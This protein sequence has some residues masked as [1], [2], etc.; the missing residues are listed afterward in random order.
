MA[1]LRQILQDYK[2]CV[3]AYS[4]GVDSV[5]L[6]HVAHQVL[7]ERSLA[8]IADSPSLPRREFQEALELGVQVQLSRAR[9]ADGGV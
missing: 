7:G 9:G 8:V 5:F 1:R 3:V 2:S 4:G 6:A